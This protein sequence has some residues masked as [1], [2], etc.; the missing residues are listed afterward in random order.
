MAGYPK[1]IVFP[2][3]SLYYE[4]AVA[5]VPQGWAW[6]AFKLSIYIAAIVGLPLLYLTGWLFRAGPMAQ[7][8]AVAFGL[9]LW[10]GGQPQ[11]FLVVGLASYW[12]SVVLAVVGIGCLYRMAQRSSA[13]W[14]AASVL[15]ATLTAWSHPLGLVVLTLAAVPF[16]LLRARQLTVREHAAWWATAAIIGLAILPLVLP[17][18]PFL[19]STNH[20]GIFYVDPNVLGRLLALVTFDRPI[21][22]LLLV[23]G[24]S[25]LIV[26]R[27][28]RPFAG[29][30]ASGALILFL[31]A[32]AGS[33]VPF[34]SRLQPVRYES[35]GAPM[36][37]WSS[38]ANSA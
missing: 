15:V 25:G 28:D 35:D 1:T 36:A 27:S 16:Y 4:L 38:T 30:L 6:P 17:A 34:V 24:A 26:R 5:A 31:I 32:Y 7:T 33:A 9:F 12:I 22:W 2:T 21:S 11:E 29:T 37:S 8:L 23:L 3:S 13:G 20:T 14:V 19:G 10:W 18:L